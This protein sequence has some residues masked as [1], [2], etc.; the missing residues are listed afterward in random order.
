MIKKAIKKTLTQFGY[1][2]TKIRT[3]SPIRWPQSEI[4][5]IEDPFLLLLTPPNSGSTA[6]AKFICQSEKVASL[7]ESDCEGQWLINGLCEIDRWWPE[8][9]VDY[10]S[11]AGVWHDVIQ[12]KKRDA[13]S[14]EYFFEKSPPHMVRYRELLEILPNARIVVNN[15]D[16]YANIG[17]QA[18]RYSGDH[19]K[20]VRREEV[21]WHLAKL[22]IYRS[23]FL[24][25]AA[26]KENC[27]VFT[28]EAFCEQPLKI[29]DLFKLQLPDIESQ[30]VV[31]VKDYESQ[32]I[33]NMNIAQIELLSKQEIQLIT[34][35][36]KDHS[37][38][39]DFFGY[40]II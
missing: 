23:Q 19:Y 4:N 40:R 7:N 21:I 14:V 29:L 10:Q 30:A 22:W 34:D 6:I 15:R 16:P 39:L 37:E 5:H 12:K 25:S 20:D 13:Q 32:P 28:Y 26:E 8:K 27:P 36:L 17:S 2:L 35:M 3:E 24:K 1:D 31:Q 18:K 11:V 33:K 38:L 9:Y